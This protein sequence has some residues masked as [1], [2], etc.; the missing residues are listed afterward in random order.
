MFVAAA[1]LEN[2]ASWPL[3]CCTERRTFLFAAENP[4]LLIAVPFDR[5]SRNSLFLIVRGR[6]SLSLLCSSIACGILFF[7]SNSSCNISASLFLRALLAIKA[8]QETPRN[9]EKKVTYKNID[10]YFKDT[11]RFPLIQQLQPCPRSLAEKLPAL[12]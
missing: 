10:Y 1:F 7:Q 9:K 12:A 5:L 4:S 11:K 3:S 2:S 6:S 8:P